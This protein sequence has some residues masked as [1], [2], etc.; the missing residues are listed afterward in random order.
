MSDAVEGRLEGA[1]GVK[2]RRT[3]APEVIDEIV[4]CIVEVAQPEKIIMFGS[5]DHHVRVGGAG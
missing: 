4:R 5:K 3:V 2:E 1:P